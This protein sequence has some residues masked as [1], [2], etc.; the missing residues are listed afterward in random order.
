[1]R[2]G[3]P[4]DSTYVSCFLATFCLILGYFTFPAQLAPNWWDQIPMCS[5]CL[6]LP[7]M[8][9]PIFH[10]P[11]F[12][13]LFLHKISLLHSNLWMIIILLVSSSMKQV[14]FILLYKLVLVHSVHYSVEFMWYF[15][16][17]PL[18]FSI[19]G[20]LYILMCC[21][22]DSFQIQM[23]FSFPFLRAND[24]R[25]SLLILRARSFLL[26]CT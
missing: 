15:D 5:Y 24:L 1:M 3:F 19:C 22:A 18:L 8:S 10:V 17:I 6:S 2:P 21:V 26:S 12:L 4:Q 23:G 25:L 20:P 13:C 11:L 9:I 14:Y 16:V 7:V